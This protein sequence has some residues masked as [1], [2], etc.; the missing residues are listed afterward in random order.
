MNAPFIMN[1]RLALARSVIQSGKGDMIMVQKA[2]ALRGMFASVGIVRIK[3]V[4]EAPSDDFDG[5]WDALPQSVKDK[6]VALASWLER[7][8]LPQ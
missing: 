2:I 7:W 3:M 4:K 1:G 5:P 8:G 6:W